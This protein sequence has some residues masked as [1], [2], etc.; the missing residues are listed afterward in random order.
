M[1]IGDISPFWPSMQQHCMLHPSHQWT[2]H[3]YFQHRNARAPPSHQNVHISQPQRNSFSPLTCSWF[4]R[5]NCLAKPTRFSFQIWFF[6]V[7]QDRRTQIIACTI[8]KRKKNRKVPVSLKGDSAR[9]KESETWR[10]IREGRVHL[11]LYIPKW[12]QAVMPLWAFR[13]PENKIP[14]KGFNDQKFLASWLFSFSY[15]VQ[16]PPLEL[17]AISSYLFLH[18]HRKL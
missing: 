12:A 15:I 6:L 13:T 18:Y 3:L 4:P 9:G 11:V 7:R 1:A 8:L 16:G 5:G 14:A 2:W 17:Q 10:G